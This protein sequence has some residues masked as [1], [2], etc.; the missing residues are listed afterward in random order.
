MDKIR[1]V[2]VVPL[3]LSRVAFRPQEVGIVAVVVRR[4]F[5]EVIRD[6]ERRRIGRRVFKVDDD[7][8]R[9]A[10]V[11]YVCLNSGGIGKKL[12][13]GGRARAACDWSF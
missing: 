9:Q 7:Y 12:P 4:P 11:S 2:E 5:V 8:L 1:R 3:G 13:G 6:V 10:T